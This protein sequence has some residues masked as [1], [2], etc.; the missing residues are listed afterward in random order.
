MTVSLF[1]SLNTVKTYVNTDVYG[2]NTC[3]SLFIT[4]HVRTIVRC[5]EQFAGYTTGACINAAE[6]ADCPVS[7]PDFSHMNW[8]VPTNFS[9]HKITHDKSNIQ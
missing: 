8:N 3:A 1:N 4:M 9:T 2:S 5:D 6:S 7:Q